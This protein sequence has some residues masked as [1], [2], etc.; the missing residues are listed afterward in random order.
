MIATQQGPL[1]STSEKIQSHENADCSWAGGSRVWRPTSRLG[2]HALWKK[3]FHASGLQAAARCRIQPHSD[4]KKTGQTCLPGKAKA[5]VCP[6]GYQRIWHQ[7]H[8][9]EW[10][11]TFVRTIIVKRRGSVVN[12]RTRGRTRPVTA[13]GWF[14]SN[15]I[16]MGFNGI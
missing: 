12:G 8:S 14:N 3:Q 16:F 1:E 10:M 2:N 11:H 6:K 5:Q 15:G 13:M 9:A 7:S 4:M